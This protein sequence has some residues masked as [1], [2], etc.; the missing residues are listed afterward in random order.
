LDGYEK[1]SR[2]DEAPKKR[3]TPREAHAELVE[4]LGLRGPEAPVED[5]A[6]DYDDDYRDFG[7]DEDDEDDGDAFDALDATDDPYSFEELTESDEPDYERRPVA[8]LS[9]D[10]AF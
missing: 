8:T 7:D 3:E 1:L 9:V 5:D 4:A 2:A 10:E 6:D